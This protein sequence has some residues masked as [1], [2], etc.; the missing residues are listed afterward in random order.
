VERSGGSTIFVFHLSRLVLVLSLLVLSIFCFLQEEVLHSADSGLGPLNKHWGRRRTPKHRKGGGGSSFSK[1]EWL[2]LA[3]CLNYVC[4]LV[5]LS[6]PSLINSYQLGIAICFLLGPRFRRGSEDPR[7]GGL[8]PPL[9]DIVNH[10]LGLY[11]SRYMAAAY[12]HAVPG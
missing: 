1:R 9:L 10:I 6:V 4:L 3:A 5:T 8:I 2:D 7:L 11:I 12:F